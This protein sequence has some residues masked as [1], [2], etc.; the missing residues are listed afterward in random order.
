MDLIVCGVVILFFLTIKTFLLIR[1]GH[2]MCRLFLLVNPPLFF[3]PLVA[4][5][6]LFPILSRAI[7]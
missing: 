4:S 6:F 1:V 7:E 5:L 2:R 3:F